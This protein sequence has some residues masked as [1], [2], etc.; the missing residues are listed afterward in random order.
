MLDTRAPGML[1]LAALLDS[2]P[3]TLTAI[4]WRAVEAIALTPGVEGATS[5]EAG[6]FAHVAVRR[7]GEWTRT[8]GLT[9]ADAASTMAVRLGRVDIAEWIATRRSELRDAETIPPPEGTG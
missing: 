1:A 9:V 5:H 2:A 8:L 3:R 6:G 4:G 7:G